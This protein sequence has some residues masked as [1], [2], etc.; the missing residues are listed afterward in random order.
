MKM[1]HFPITVDFHLTSTFH[2]NEP[3]FWPAVNLQNVLLMANKVKLLSVCSGPL[4]SSHSSHSVPSHRS[5]WWSSVTSVHTHTHTHI[6]T[7]THTHTHTSNTHIQNHKPTLL[8]QSDSVPERRR[9]LRSADE[10]EWTLQHIHTHKQ[11]SVRA[12]LH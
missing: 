5:H 10:H 4:V 2:P 11:T 6:H 7:H 12:K 8:S 3:R 1:L 9:H